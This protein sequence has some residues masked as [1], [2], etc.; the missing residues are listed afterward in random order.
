MTERYFRQSEIKKFK[1][2]PRS[3]WLSYQRSGYGWKPAP[4]DRP[5]SGKR[6]VGTLV[7][8]AIELYRNPPEGFTGK[9]VWRN[10]IDSARLA[11]V[12]DLG[13]MSVQQLSKEW[14]SDFDLAERMVEGYIEWLE[15]EGSDAGEVTLGT[16]VEVTLP[17]GTIRGDEVFLVMHLDHVLRDQITGRIIVSDYKTVQSL[18][19]A[20][21]ILQID[22]QGQLYCM[23]ATYHYGEPVRN[24][25]H[26]MLRKVKR[27]GTAKPPFYGRQNVAFN[28][29]Q[30]DSSWKQLVATLDRMV[31]ALQ[32]LEADE[33]VHHYA[34]VPTPHK[35]CTWD[36]D[37]LGICPMFDEGS[38]WRKAIE[39]SGLFVRR[40]GKSNDD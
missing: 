16:E 5:A 18:D 39:E 1:R 9:L 23:G 33:E 4:S 12:A 19:Q 37:F 40:E 8:A 38:H 34:V 30:I 35:D 22:T 29:T 13:L 31:E 21:D 2:C 17:I 3:W 32:R 25:R 26:D 28:E 14:Q 27:T 7:H 36:C 15:S 10:A 11:L 6:D 20:A 24:F